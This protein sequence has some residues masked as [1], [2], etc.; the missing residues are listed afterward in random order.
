MSTVALPR[1]QVA[2]PWTSTPQDWSPTTG[3]LCLSDG[4][5]AATTVEVQRCAAGRL[6]NAY[7]VSLHDIEVRFPDAVD[8]GVARAVLDV[9]VPAILRADP[10]CRRVVFSV[11]RDDALAAQ[12]AEAAGF[13][14]V[15]DVDLPDAE[16]SLFVSEPEWVTEVD[17]DLDRVPGV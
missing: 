3:V 10:E 2:A 17:M 4:N 12:A 14:F 13:R 5:G 11:P 15:V 1:I 9:L 16:L 7:P 8:A 6:E